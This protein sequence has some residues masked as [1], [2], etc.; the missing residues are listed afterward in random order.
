MMARVCTQQHCNDSCRHQTDVVCLNLC[1]LFV[2]IKYKHMLTS[3]MLFVKKRLV[4]H[5]F[6]HHA[7]FSIF[8][9]KTTCTVYEGLWYVYRYEGMWDHQPGEGGQEHHGGH[10]QP[11][12]QTADH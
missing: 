1:C 9:C 11:L 10:R 7:F 2:I 8:V 4:V 3:D 5:Y 6:V 12:G